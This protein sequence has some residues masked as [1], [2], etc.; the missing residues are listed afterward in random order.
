MKHLDKTTLRLAATY[1]AIIMVMCVSYSTVFY[2]TSAH[3]LERRRPPGAAGVYRGLDDQ[4]ENFL[5]L[6]ESEGKRALLF[7]LIGVNVMTLL[8]GALV[9]YLLAEQTMRPIKEN[10]ESQIRFVGDASHELRTPLT[11]L[12]TAN[13]VALRKPHLSEDEAR[14]VISG[15]VEDAKRL[16]SLTDSLLDLLKEDE[17]AIMQYDVN[18]QKVIGGA[19]NVVATQGLA[20][21]ISVDDKSRPYVVV[22]NEQSLTQVITILLDNAIKY[23]PRESTVVISTKKQGK[24]IDIT[25]ADKG[26]GMDEETQDRI[27][28]RFYRADQARA[29]HGTHQGAA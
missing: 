11:A 28:T 6:R 20:R 7:Q 9:S 27:F 29:R 1:L 18:V 12:R 21:G 17:R 13:E 4:F 10:M 8:V 15:T 19:M 25:V 23:S 3:Q 14:E 22:G 5:S 26:I 2:A 16:Q 24:Y